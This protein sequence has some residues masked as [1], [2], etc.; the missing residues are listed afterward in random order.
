MA[1]EPTKDARIRRQ[2][3][4]GTA[5][6]GIGKIIVLVTWF[7]LTPF[8]LRQLGIEQYG[9]WVLVGSIV[10]YGSLLD[11]GIGGA[12]VK[13]VAEHRSRNDVEKARALIATSLWLY[14]GL[15]LLAIVVSIVLASL[16][17]IVF[18]LSP[19]QS[20]TARWLV[21][22]MGINVGVALP[23]AVASS[24]LKGLQRYEITNIISTVALFVSAIATVVVLLLGGGVVAM[25]TVNIPI[26]LAVQIPSI[27]AIRR[28]APDLRF[29][30]RGARRDLAWEVL[31]FSSSLFLNDVAGRLQS[32]TDELVIAA[33]MAVSAVAPY[34]IARK[35][36]EAAQLLTE[37]FL[38][39]LLPIAS[40][41]RASQGERI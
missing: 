18:H 25:V 39:V 20:V 41:L 19:E 32:K 23:G 6:N 4:T 13:Y 33:S 28:I 5:A 40:S 26:T 29:S 16:F 3:I 35:L 38:K 1:A 8:I 31:S 11:F 7:F 22:V 36:S 30:W 15:G 21:I 9:L 17:P 10:A 27:L 24:V 37:Q 2:I 12:V 14:C 34:S